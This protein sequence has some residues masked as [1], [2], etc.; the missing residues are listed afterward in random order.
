MGVHYATSRDRHQATLD[1]CRVF[2]D[3]G[4]GHLNRQ[5]I[6]V[7]EAGGVPGSTFVELQ[8]EAVSM[9][10][11]IL[12][13]DD[14][15]VTL[16]W[17]F[18]RTSTLHSKQGEEQTAI[19]T[20]LL[21]L[22]AQGFTMA[23]PYV[24]KLLCDQLERVK[25]KIREKAKIEVPLSRQVVIIADPLDV[26]EPNQ[27]FLQVT[28]RTLDD[29]PIGCLV[30]HVLVARNPC[31]LPSDVQK[32][33]CVDHPRL[34]MYEDVLI[35]SVKDFKSAASR[36]SGGDYD[37]DTVW[38]CW[39]PRLVEPFDGPREPPSMSAA[40]RQ[41][42][43]GQFIT[44]GRRL[45]DV[46]AC[47]QAAMDDPVQKRDALS[48]L[49]AEMRSVWVRHEGGQLNLVSHMWK[50]AAEMW[51][52]HDQDTLRLAR[53][54]AEL[55]DAPKT[56]KTMQ[57]LHFEA[58]KAH[59]QQRSLQTPNWHVPKRKRAEG[60][61]AADKRFVS[62]KA[63]GQMLRDLERHTHTHRP[64]PNERPPAPGPLPNGAPRLDGGLQSL[65]NKMQSANPAQWQQD[66]GTMVAMRD[67]YNRDM[68]G[69][70]ERPR[71]IDLTPDGVTTKHT[72][73]FRKHVADNSRPEGYWGALAYL[74]TQERD[75]WQKYCW[76]VARKDICRI[77]AESMG[78]TFCIPTHIF[79]HLRIKG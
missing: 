28:G 33:Q 6:A 52:L 42:Y 75:P 25:T 50:C 49:S 54:S 21:A 51:G 67:A 68:A 43:E 40:E 31:V 24:H 62:N 61:G 22:M 65:I 30:G 18:R 4:P 56:G 1:V 69:V 34:R 36:L 23:E 9:S 27:A 79:A 53:L 77:K 66:R 16:R 35:L 5:F 64:Q 72:L 32:M 26:L 59:L 20:D 15:K 73:L 44:D 55:V 47:T 76:T 37:G 17:L 14:P 39:D 2:G 71:S 45:G 7:L 11:A 19:T 58:L 63:Q 29:E 13:S 70:L 78:D 57:R 74:V 41:D 60:L 38:V 10:A 46:M 12:F 48:R 8:R 3:T